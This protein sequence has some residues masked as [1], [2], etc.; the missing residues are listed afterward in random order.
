ME[1]MF[2]GNTLLN[3]TNLFS[4]NDNKKNDKM[5]FKCFKDKYGTRTKSLV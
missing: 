3:C 4:L 5:M 2:A 1:D